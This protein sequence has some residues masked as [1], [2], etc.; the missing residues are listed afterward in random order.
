MTTQIAHTTG[1]DLYQYALCDELM[2]RHALEQREAHAAIA[3]ALD[4]IVG[5]EDAETI[6]V[7]ETPM[8]PGPAGG[9]Q[10]IEVTD[11]AV[12]LIRDHVDY[13]YGP[14]N[15]I[16]IRITDLKQGID[17]WRADKDLTRAEAIRRLIDLGLD[18]SRTRAGQRLTPEQIASDV[19]HHGKDI[20]RELTL[21]ITA[22][23]KDD[24]IGQRPV[25]AQSL[26]RNHADDVRLD[27]IRR[28]ISIP[29]VGDGVGAEWIEIYEVAY[30]GYGPEPSS[31]G[32]RIYWGWRRLFTDRAAAEAYFASMAAEHMPRHPFHLPAG[33][34]GASSDAAAG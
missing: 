18:D 30:K 26:R 34:S 24:A 5:I 1:N 17:E 22:A 16:T 10:W 23:A 13:L 29:P 2:E 9:D 11:L 31:V 28:P 4:H 15:N 12:G 7:A 27:L 3:A 19:R 21:R 8:R 33:P 20:P 6:I 14:A 32:G 25:H